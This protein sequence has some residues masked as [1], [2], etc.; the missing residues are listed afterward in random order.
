MRFL[1]ETCMILVS[2]DANALYGDP[3]LLKPFCQRLLAHAGAGVCEVHMSPVVLAELDRRLAADMGGEHDAVE[4]RIRTVGDRYQVPV[5]EMLSE[6]DALR[7]AAR[8]RVDA[9]REELRTA[10]GFFVQPWPEE[11]VP[12]VVER[13]LARRRPFLD[14]EKVGT[15]GHRDTII[16]LGT[17]QLADERPDDDVIFVTKDK[18]FLEKD[19]L[20][21]H[22]REDLEQ[23]GVTAARVRR[24]PDIYSVVNFLDTAAAE[25]VDKR[26]AAA[27]AAIRQA[28]HEYT[29]ELAKDVQWGWEWDPRDGGRSEP[30]LDADL[31]EDMEEVTVDYVETQLEVT[32]TP[33]NPES[34]QPVECKHRVQISFTGFMAKSDWFSED[35][36][37]IELWDSDFNDHYVVVAAH[38][39]LELTTKVT[40]DPDADAADVDELVS[41][42]VIDH[43]H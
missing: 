38:R 18:G 3:L 9:R 5:T 15:I 28:L 27:R 19:D 25:V 17:V 30:S 40:Y 29:E 37:G 1:G 35:Y 22:L 6:L 42:R 20:H 4:T 11:S 32:I 8:D 36:H 14:I 16:W 7:S 23:V 39:V 13:E 26:R 10:P 2:L 24:M 43:S 12:S 31:P 34:G 21:H 41:S 33:D